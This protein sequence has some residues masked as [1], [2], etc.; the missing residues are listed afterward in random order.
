M[1]AATA[2]LAGCGGGGSASA[3]K[4][5][6]GALDNA[7]FVFVQSP[8]TG[9][10]VSSGFRVSGCSSTFEGN[11]IWLLR[12]RTG[13]LLA[14]GHTEGGS[15]GPGSFDFTVSYSLAARQVGSLTVAEPPT[16]TEGFPPPRDVVP[17]VLD[18]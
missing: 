1:L 7:A 16:T 8:A 6:D 5:G 4:N 17:L 11:V 14:H 10:R 3:C 15:Q 13:R 9:E 2:A 18:A 12:S